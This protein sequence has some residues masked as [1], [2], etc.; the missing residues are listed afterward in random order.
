MLK[1]DAVD[2][3]SRLVPE[4][5]RAEKL[6]ALRAAISEAHRLGITSVQ[7]ISPTQDELQLLDEIRKDGDLAVRVYASIAVRRAF[8][9]PTSSS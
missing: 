7:S 6:A 9:R 8:P 1:D 3:V 2:L 4:P 5:T